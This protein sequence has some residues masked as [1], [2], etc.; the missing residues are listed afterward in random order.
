MALT[1]GIPLLIDKENS[2]LLQSCV[3]SWVE[4][5]NTVIS[6]S[7]EAPVATDVA[8]SWPGTGQG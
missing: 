4:A 3:G 2:H 7:L 6:S 5:T 8:S 1:P